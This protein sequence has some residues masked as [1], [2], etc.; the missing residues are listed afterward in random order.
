MEPTDNAGATVVL[1]S[2][3]ES[4][5][6]VVYEAIRDAIGVEYEPRWA[7][8]AP[9]RASRHSTRYLSLDRP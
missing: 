9:S 8:I 2:K 4:L 5:T 3:P 1:E 7:H 6:D